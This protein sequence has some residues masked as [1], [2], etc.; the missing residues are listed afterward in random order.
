MCSQLSCLYRP[1]MRLLYPPPFPMKFKASLPSLTLS[2]TWLQ[3]RMLPQVRTLLQVRKL[4][5]RPRQK[6]LEDVEEIDRGKVRPAREKMPVGVKT[7]GD[8]TTKGGNSTKSRR[9][10]KISLHATSSNK[11]RTIVASRREREPR[12]IRTCRYN[13]PHLL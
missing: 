11:Q 7:T 2:W 6:L 4:K 5:R 12:N 13:R 9:T 10:T 3:A 1:F 8:A